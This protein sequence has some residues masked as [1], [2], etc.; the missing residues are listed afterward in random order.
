MWDCLLT[1]N[2]ASYG[3]GACL[4]PL[5]KC[6][7][8]NNSATVAGGGVCSNSIYTSCIIYYNS[9]PAGANYSDTARFS[10]CCTAPLP[11]SGDGN[12]TDEPTFI[13]QAGGNL[14]LQTGSPCINAGGNVTGSIDLDGRPRIVGGR[15]DIG[16]YEFQGAGMGEF[17]AWLQRYGLLT[18]GSADYTDTDR[19][20]LNNWQE[21]RAGTNPTNALSVL[22]MLAA[23]E[24]SPGVTVTW[25]SVNGLTYFLERSTDLTAQPALSVVQSN[26]TGQADMTS[27]TDTNAAGSGPFFYRVGVQ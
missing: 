16:A 14:R 1:R 17:I 22:K 24:G 20:G 27:F 11:P 6:T 9:A 21:W 25:R 26:L 8:V 13:D 15:I 19:D 10:Y 7:V 2:T 18:S 23:A 5:Y 4:G 3:G 12:I